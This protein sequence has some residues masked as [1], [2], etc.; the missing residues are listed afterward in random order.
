TALGKYHPAAASSLR[1]LAGLHYLMGRVP[2]AEALYRQALEAASKSVGENHPEYAHGLR[3]L[4][5]MYQSVGNHAAA[6]PLLRQ[7]LEILRQAVGADHPDHA[8]CLHNL[9]ALCAATGREAE[10]L[11]LMEQVAARE[12]RFL[13]LI[14]AL[15]GP[16]TR[17]LLLRPLQENYHK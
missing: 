10:A 2:E 15:T 6:E 3:L 7:P 14:L 11:T 4:A 1:E 9:A 5:G 16:N 17:T 13:P 12:E 8:G